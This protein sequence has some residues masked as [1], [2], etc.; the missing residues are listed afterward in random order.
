[1]PWSQESGQERERR[2]IHGL[3]PMLTSQEV[4]AWPGVKR[5]TVLRKR[6][7]WGL[8]GRRMR[9]RVVFVRADVARLMKRGV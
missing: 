2:F 8:R 1:M 3:E 9:N 6:E 7:A 5:E 4:A